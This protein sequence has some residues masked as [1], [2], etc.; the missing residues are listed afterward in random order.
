MP[1]PVFPHILTTGE[2]Q[3]SKKFSQELEDPSMQ[4]ELEGGY[5]V[6][7]ARHT[8]APRRTWSSGFT[9][10]KQAGKAELEA[11]WNE[12]RGGSVIF[13]WRNPQDGQDYLVRFK[14]G[15]S[16]KFTYVGAGTNYRWDV[17]FTVEEA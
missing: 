12:V 1:T 4:S 13:Q 6:S 2:E 7:R 16:L 10:I 14:G 9:Y 8:R 11:F 3:D 15:S 5:V 17:G